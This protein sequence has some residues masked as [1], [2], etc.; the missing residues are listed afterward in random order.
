MRSTFVSHLM[1]TAPLWAVKQVQPFR[2]RIVHR[3]PRRSGILRALPEGKLPF[4]GSN[5]IRTWKGACLTWQK[6]DCG[7]WQ[8]HRIFTFKNEFRTS[9][10]LLRPKLNLETRN[11]FEVYQ[12][13]NSKN[14]QNVQ[15]SLSNI[16]KSSTNDDPNSKISLK[17]S[18]D[19]RWWLF[20]CFAVKTWYQPFNRNC[21]RWQ[22]P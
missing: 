10:S 13:S 5:D 11:T 4:S 9:C 14:Y 8:Q 17:I 2:I 20:P 3:P 1:Q 22:A 15:M 18:Y 6:A 21:K 16:S 7:H 19:F 12:L